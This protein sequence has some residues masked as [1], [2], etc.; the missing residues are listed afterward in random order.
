M[1][2][3]DPGR[4]SALSFS[5]S[6]CPRRHSRTTTTPPEVLKGQSHAF[7]AAPGSTPAATVTGFVSGELTLAPVGGGAAI[8]GA[9]NG[10]TRFLCMRTARGRGFGPPPPCDSTQL[11]SGAGV[12]SAD[13]RITQAGVEFSDIVLLPAVQSCDELTS[14]RRRA[15]VH[16]ARSRF[17]PRRRRLCAAVRRGGRRRQGRR[18]PRSPDARRRGPRARRPPRRASPAPAA[19]PQRTSQAVS[20]ARFATRR[21]GRDADPADPDGSVAR[22]VR[23]DGVAHSDDHTPAPGA[24]DS[25]RIVGRPNKPCDPRLNGRALRSERR[26]VDGHD[27][28]EI[29][30]RG[31]VDAHVSRRLHR[32][33][34]SGL[35]QHQPQPQHARRGPRHPRRARTRRSPA[36]RR[37][38]RSRR[39][40][41]ATA[42]LNHP[43]R[44]RSPSS[45][46]LGRSPWLRPAG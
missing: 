13:V 39:P 10:Q 46:R 36:R 19:K 9:V 11:V 45:V 14:W 24:R 8:T 41:P 15:P 34:G 25:D 2:R 26:A 20:A 35:D 7:P 6:P 44:D 27:L 30:R 40:R 12:L 28:I 37:T 3:L 29:R 33:Q 21:L 32:A 4:R 31:H 18:S 5:Y 42:V 22:A 23:V 17:W 1:K 43:S 38:W 16:R